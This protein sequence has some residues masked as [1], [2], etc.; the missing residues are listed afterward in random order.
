M[1]TM[2]PVFESQYPLLRRLLQEDGMLHHAL[3]L[4]GL[5][6]I[7]KLAFAR[8]LA[9]GLLCETRPQNADHACGRCPGCR[10]FAAGSHPDFRL[11]EREVVSETR[12]GRGKETAQPARAWEISIDQVRALDSFLTSTSA[13]G[14]A[15][16]VLIA[17]ADTLSTPAANALLKMLEEPGRSTFFLLSTHEPS[18]LP[19]TVR[20]RCRQVDVP[21]PS[22]SE[23]AHWLMQD[24]GIDAAEA[25]RLLA[26]SGMAPLHARAL[27]DPVH[28]TV[29][30]SLL[31]SIGALP[32][33]GLDTVADK[34]GAVGAAV[35]YP[36]LLRWISDLLRVHAGARPRFYPEFA[37]RMGTL[38]QRCPLVRLA[39]VSAVLQ[40]QAALVRHPLNP[41]LFLESALAT[42]LD[43]FAGSHTT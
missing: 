29:H 6:G 34:A 17:P 31:E 2:L 15:R 36:L 9:Q 28:L 23:A 33:T 30:R 22:A 1:T 25:R 38:A 3:L 11:L 12:G 35:W 10:W 13:R 40:R 26:W 19:P 4:Q 43:A 21:P 37:S 14:D 41:R 20:S 7:G 8:A 5:P 32:D 39:E 18:A 16:V 24:A 27:A 42:Y